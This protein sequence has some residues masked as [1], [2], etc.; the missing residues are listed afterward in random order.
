MIKHK[1]LRSA[2]QHTLWVHL[3]YIAVLLDVRIEKKYYLEGVGPFCEDDCMEDCDDI[4]G[5]L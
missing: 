3:L 4:W 1:S 2:K 5:S